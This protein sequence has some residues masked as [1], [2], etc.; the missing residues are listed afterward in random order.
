M[1]TTVSE[2]EKQANDFLR[3]T[4]T[5][6]TV[7][8]LKFDKHF[9][10][11]D[12]KRNIFKITLKNDKHKYSFNFGSSISD[13]CKPEQ[14]RKIDSNEKT[15]IYF[16]FGMPKTKLVHYVTFGHKIETNYPVLLSIAN[17]E[18]YEHLLNTVHIEKDY[19]RYLN[20][21]KEYNSKITIKY[22]K[23]YARQYGLYLEKTVSLDEIY[24]KI[25]EAIHK[26]VKK[27]EA[28]I[29]T[30]LINRKDEIIKPSAYDIL[31]CLTKYN[32]YD[33][34]N[35]CSEYGYDTDSRKAE[36]IYKAVLDEWD[37]ISKLFND[38]ELEMLSEIQ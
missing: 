4:N 31:T 34:E 18:S 11:D 19:E 3:K 30:V 23:D 5:S 17:G 37:N 28:E 6:I 14:I 12:H 32:P 33:F 7:K 25:R 22:N 21:V 20:D 2:Y 38:E 35:F 10:D 26:A 24:A 9:A 27:S 36:K 8:Y 16:G 29:E 1:K 13:S 15:D